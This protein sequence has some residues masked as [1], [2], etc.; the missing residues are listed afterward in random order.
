MPLRLLKKYF[1]P[2]R[3]A[4]KI[5]R[6]RPKVQSISRQNSAQKLATRV[7]A[8]GIS[9]ELLFANA[10]CMYALKSHP[11]C[12]S[13]VYVLLVD[14]FFSPTTQTTTGV[15]NRQYPS[16]VHD[17]SSLISAAGKQH[18]ASSSNAVDLIKR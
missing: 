12:S 15:Y 16:L 5:G 13:C 4:C 8:L 9:K 17:N 18:D 10:A 3:L 7:G 11:S 14:V 6:R 1:H 2:R